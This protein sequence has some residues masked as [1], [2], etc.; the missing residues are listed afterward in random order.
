MVEVRW[1]DVVRE[2]SLRIR[3]QKEIE[4]LLKEKRARKGKAITAS[5]ATNI[6]D[7]DEDEE[8]DDE[9]EDE[10][11]MLREGK[12]G[13]MGTCNT[14]HEIDNSEDSDTESI[15]SNTPNTKQA[16]SYRGNQAIGL[17][18]VIE[19]TDWEDAEIID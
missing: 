3:G 13:R 4:K 19:D 18:T 6:D 16:T 7:D 10:I 14:W 17:Q 12:F 9:L 15:I 2:L 5:Q 8:N 1:V 11:D